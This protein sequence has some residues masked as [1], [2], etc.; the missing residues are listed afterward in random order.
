MGNL[1]SF[2]GFRVK[3][4]LEIIVEEILPELESELRRATTVTGAELVKEWHE[5]QRI[6]GL[7]EAIRRSTSEEKP[8]LSI[9]TALAELPF[10]T[11]WN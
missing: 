3:G 8:V 10:M 7:R 1:P 5:L 6:R 11:M 2:V 9:R 4:L